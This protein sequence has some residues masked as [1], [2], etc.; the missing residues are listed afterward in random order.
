MAKKPI[1]KSSQAS[2]ELHFEDVFLQ[3]LLGYE[4]CQCQ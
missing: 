2:R 4:H 1:D 3:T